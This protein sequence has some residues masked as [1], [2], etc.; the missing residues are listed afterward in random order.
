MIETPDAPRPTTITTPPGAYDLKVLLHLVKYGHIFTGNK[1]IAITGAL[2]RLE[3]RG[4]V[5]KDRNWY[6]TAAGAQL[7][8]EKEQGTN[9]APK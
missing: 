6:V 8:K 2:R 4:L 5:G 3:K 1:A 9:L 7:A